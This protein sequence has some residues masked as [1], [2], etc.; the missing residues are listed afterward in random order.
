M[1]LE[2]CAAYC[3]SRPTPYRFMGITAGF[4]CCKSTS[5]VLA[6]NLLMYLAC[7]NFFENIF[8]NFGG[9]CDTP[10]PGDH[11]EVYGCGGQQQWQP[12]A[13]TYQ[14]RQ[15]NA[16]FIIPTPVPSVGLWKGL[17][18]YTSVSVHLS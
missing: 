3:E 12:L 7:D 9:G 10:C 16:N 8:E 14:N 6:R 1:T 13:S 17:G 18:C 2:K 4:Q 5:N 11:S 15:L